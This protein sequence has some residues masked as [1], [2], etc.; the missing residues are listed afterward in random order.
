VKLNRASEDAQA[1][2][3]ECDLGHRAQGRSVRGAKE[4]HGAPRV[5]RAISCEVHAAGYLKRAALGRQNSV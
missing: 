5:E 3:N 1:A 4:M 2:R